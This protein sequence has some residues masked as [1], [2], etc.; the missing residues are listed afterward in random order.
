M[1]A[2]SPAP[3]KR[4]DTRIFALTAAVIVIIALGVAAAALGDRILSPEPSPATSNGGASTVSG[5]VTN[6]GDTHI[7]AMVAAADD[8]LSGESYAH[9][10]RQRCLVIEAVAARA[11]QYGPIPEQS[12][13][14]YW[15][16]ALDAALGGAAWCRALTRSSDDVYNR[17][18]LDAARLMKSYS[19]QTRKR[20]NAVRATGS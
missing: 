19:E 7:A 2:T 14:A 15:G 18:V 20:I 12:A 13:Q 10:T 1:P 11:E 16:R 3:P 4:S 17:K 6:G 9:R 8:V 5:W